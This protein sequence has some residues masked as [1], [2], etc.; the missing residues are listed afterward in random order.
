[1]FLPWSESSPVLPWGLSLHIS[2]AGTVAGTEEKRSS[3]HHMS[4]LEAD[5]YGVQAGDLMRLVVDSEQGGM[6]EGL[7]CRVS[8][9]E[10]LEVHLDTDEG[11]ALDLVH[12]RKVYVEK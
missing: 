11:N 12:A 6:L 2:R 3:V 9:A 4:P 5:Y 7:I 1:M 10:K 8:D